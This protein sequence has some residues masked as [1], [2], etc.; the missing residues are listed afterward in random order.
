MRLGTALLV[1]AVAL[2]ACRHEPSRKNGDGT[3]MTSA[4]DSATAGERLD[5]NLVDGPDL[6][7]GVHERDT[8]LRVDLGAG[9]VFV[10]RH[11]PGS[12]AGGEAIGNFSASVPAETVARLRSALGTVDLASL[13]AAAEG[14]PGFTGIELRYLAAGKTQRVVYTVRDAEL[15]ERLEP[16]TSILDE[17]L[18]LALA[19]PLQAIELTVERAGDG[20]VLV[21]KNVGSEAIAVRDPRALPADDAGAEAAGVRVALR[22]R[23]EPGVTPPPPEWRFLA[24]APAPA[25]APDAPPLVLAPGAELRCPTLAWKPSEPSTRHLVQAVFSSYRAS[26]IDSR[27]LLVRGRVYSEAILVQP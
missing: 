3:T 22:P 9:V 2:S 11:Q 26:A 17:L 24:L 5:Y 21:L 25:A 16:I 12:D 20:F 6:G 23:T 8:R 4:G 7:A 18:V 13:P 14:G 10:E 15:S 19:H 27:A 1:L